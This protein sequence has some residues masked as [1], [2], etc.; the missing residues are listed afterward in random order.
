MQPET[1]DTCPLPLHAEETFSVE[2]LTNQGHGIA[3]HG[4]WVVMIPFTVPGDRVK[5]RVWRNHKN[6]SEAD[7][8]EV[9]EASPSR[10][11][12]ACPYFTE[13]GGCQYQHIR[14]GDQL[15][16]KRRQVQELLG[17][18]A[19]IEHEVLAVV[20]SPET[21]A[22]RTKITP[23]FDR[24]R[25]SKPDKIG[26]RHARSNAK[27]VD[28]ESCLLAT[29]AMNT[30]LGE[31]R[32]EWLP[33][34]PGRK[35]GV[36]LFIRQHAAGISTDTHDIIEENVGGIRFKFPAGQF[37]QN[38]PFILEQLAGHVCDEA[39]GP[40]FLVDAYCGSGL[41]A[42]FAARR[43]ELVY[44]IEISESSIRWAEENAV[45]NGIGNSRFFSGDASG[46]FSEIP[47]EG[48]DCTVIIDPPRAGASEDFLGQLAAFSPKKIV[49]VSCNPA[50]Q[51]R[52]LRALVSSGYLLA[53]VQPFDLFP[54][55]KHLE[56]VMT[57]AKP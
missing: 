31:L 11:P 3:R 55:T 7:L 5:A 8:L 25:P 53:K 34:I 22:Y 47:A 13:C 48:K 14:Y 29:E 57:F 24:H 35:K 21:Y 18:M 27:L 52:D 2:S 28:I 38:N 39:E 6:F 9:I 42:L 54:Q 33:Q 30:T 20:P 40:R 43:F 17:R 41:F 32:A 44:G 10:I 26:F 56:C 36:T 4:G 50:T 15:E 51:M 37:F 46:I 16:W 45:Q 23:H 12:P 1:G 49:Y 19:G